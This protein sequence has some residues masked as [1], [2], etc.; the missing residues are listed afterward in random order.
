MNR[1]VA[2]FLFLPL[3]VLSMFSC[4]SHRYS[5]ES[6]E[7]RSITVDS[8]YDV[9]PD[10]EAMAFIAPYKTKVDSVMSPVIGQVACDME[11][12]RPESKLSNLLADILI[13]AGKDY[14]EKPVVSVY[15]IGGMR[16]SL[17]A[18]NVTVGD[19]LDVAPFDNKICFMTMKGSLLLELFKQIAKRGGEAVNHAVRAIITK[20]GKLVSLRI[21]G[22]NVDPDAEYRIATIDYLVEGNDGMPAFR[23][24]YDRNM[25]VDNRNNLRFIIM[26]YFRENME[27]GNVVD[28]VIEGRITTE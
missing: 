1:F 26:D 13:W 25:L 18:G 19:V 4:S 9:M 2:S 6:V 12:D 3:V 15:N 5:V 24:G 10:T 8:T 23:Q 7:F 16:A 22:E 20:D 14:G 11:A 28:A 21:N 27:K 17:S